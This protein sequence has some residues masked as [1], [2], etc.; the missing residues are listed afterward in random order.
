MVRARPQHTE[1]GDWRARVLTVAERGARAVERTALAALAAP[2]WSARHGR[3]EVGASTGR[4]A[5]VSS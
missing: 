5:G 3:R 1:E 2:S 4:A